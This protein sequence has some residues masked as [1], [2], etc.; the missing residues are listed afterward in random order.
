M[1]SIGLKVGEA[2]ILFRLTGLHGRVSRH[3][4]LLMKRFSGLIEPRLPDYPLVQVTSH[5][6]RREAAV[7][8]KGASINH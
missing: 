8:T 1:A 2:R 7:V 6:S 4:P 3:K 5:P